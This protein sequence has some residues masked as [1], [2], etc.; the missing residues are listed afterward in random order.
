MKRFLYIYLLLFILVLLSSCSRGEN[1]YEIDVSYNKKT[2]FYRIEYPEY[3]KVY[4]KEVEVN[5]KKSKSFE[6]NI[7][8]IYNIKS[9]N[10]VLNMS[11]V[12]SDGE[13]KY[14]NIIEEPLVNVD[15]YIDL[16]IDDFSPN[17]DATQKIDKAYIKIE[18]IGNIDTKDI[19]SFSIKEYKDGEKP[20]EKILELPIVDLPKPGHIARSNPPFILLDRNTDKLNI[21]LAQTKN[22][23]RENA[24]LERF[25]T[26]VIN[27]EDLNMY[28]INGKNFLQ[29]KNTLEKGKWYIKIEDARNPDSYSIYSFFI[30]DSTRNINVLENINFTNTRPFILADKTSLDIL[31]YFYGLKRNRNN[32]V[33]SRN[34]LYFKE[35]VEDRLGRWSKNKIVYEGEAEGIDNFA[36][37]SLES[38]SVIMSLYSYLNPTNSIA[39]N[40]TISM[41]KD[42]SDINP[43]EVSGFSEVQASVILANSLLAPFDLLYNSFDASELIK[44]KEAIIKNGEVL[45]DY[46]IENPA[47]YKD[48]NTIKYA[49]TLAIISIA[50]YNENLREGEVRNWYDFSLNYINS[51]IIP[52]IGSDGALKSSVGSSFEVVMPILMLATTLK[53]AGIINYFETPEFKNLAKYLSVVGYPSGYTFPVGDTY[54]N[55]KSDSRLDSGAR[56]SV[57]ELLSREY[58]NILY[59]KY[60]T[61]GV[62]EHTEIKYLPFM[63]VWNAHRVDADIP[64]RYIE[65]FKYSYFKDIETVIYNE[66][67]LNKNNAYFSLYGKGSKPN[68]SHK[69]D[70][71]DRLSFEYYNY[72]DKIIAEAGFS[73]QTNENT[74]S[75]IKSSLAHSTISVND[76][77]MLNH[78][79]SYS[80][81]YSTVNFKNILYVH[82][83]FD[84]DYAYDLKLKNYDRRFYYLKPN[85]MIVKDDIEVLPDITKDTLKVNNNYTSRFTSKLPIIYNAIDNKF[86]IDG[87]NS[88]T[89]IY[90]LANEDIEMSVN[91]MNIDEQT[92]L[93]IAEIKTKENVKSFSTWSIFITKPKSFR[94]RITTNIEVV[95]YNNDSL[96]FKN[97]NLTYRIY[98]NNIS[99][100]FS[101]LDYSFFRGNVNILSD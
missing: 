83:K 51:I 85:I 17:I 72:G 95:E 73:G 99:T 35:Y 47:S 78:I 28:S 14:T 54:I 48:V 12:L 58:N 80:Y 15:V 7:L 33:L 76:K 69:L 56:T 94:N 11:L 46:L 34:L 53:N 64:F 57:M 77:E 65:P 98:P 49:S 97:R 101:T 59:K 88:I 62:S 81:I 40:E 43:S 91:E 5:L 16:N 36:F 86:V 10:R 84:L 63:L 19:L 26:S 2:G 41:L 31:E 1:T 96:I 74:Y 66:S 42:I 9:D 90:I 25:N 67:I 79:G 6:K 37:V 8:F 55:Y 27:T 39:R 75:N 60:A 44:I 29:T 61:F 71:N 21:Y 18:T 87:D 20:R 52:F 23:E 50:M 13:N 68:S 30:D 82:G 32:N 22:F 92:P 70:H 38:H 24:A 4:P 89:D 100:N 45:Y 3:N 93:Y